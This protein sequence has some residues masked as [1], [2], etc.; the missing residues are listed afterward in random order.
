MPQ[1][2]PIQLLQIRSDLCLLHLYSRKQSALP[3]DVNNALNEL[4]G[5]SDHLLQSRRAFYERVQ[6]TEVLRGS[7][8]AN[9]EVKDYA[10]VI[11]ALRREH[12]EEKQRLLQDVK[13]NWFHRDYYDA[14][15][16]ESE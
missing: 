12:E 1:T 16:V 13:Q 3:S 15:T 4:E 8:E 2:A 9:Q 5:L 11:S 7:Q 10:N 14:Y 6:N